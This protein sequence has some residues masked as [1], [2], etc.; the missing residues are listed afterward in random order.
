MPVIFHIL[1]VRIDSNRKTIIIIL[2]YKLLKAIPV[3]LILRANIAA[4][5]K[6]HII[7]FHYRL[8]ANLIALRLR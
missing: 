8:R 1:R 6:N 7:I 4:S 5:L 2:Y 3:I